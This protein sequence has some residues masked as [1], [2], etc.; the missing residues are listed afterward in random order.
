VNKDGARP[1]NGWS[2]PTVILAALSL[3]ASAGWAWVGISRSDSD[4][5][6]NQISAQ[7][8]RLHDQERKI[9]VLEGRVDDLRER[10]RRR[11]DE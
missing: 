5:I 11:R 7:T 10:D 6:Q 4:K 1:S 3:V 8:Q 2:Q 9:A